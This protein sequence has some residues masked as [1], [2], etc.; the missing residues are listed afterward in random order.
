[1]PKKTRCIRKRKHFQ[2][3]KQRGGSTIHAAVYRN[4]IAEVRRL[5]ESGVDVNEQEKGTMYGL[6]PLMIAIVK[7]YPQIVNL[8]L[9]APG[10]NVNAKSNEGFTALHKAAEH[11]KINYV[12]QLLAIEGIHINAQNILHA[13]P[14]IIACE[15]NNADIVELLLSKEGID[16]NKKKRITN[17]TALTISCSY[18]FL[19]IARMLLA[20]DDIDVN[21]T[22]YD[23]S[24]ALMEGVKCS[25]EIT[26]LLLE[27]EGIDINAQND[28]GDTALM[29]A[30]SMDK[31]EIV[32]IL[33]ARDEIDV[34]ITN[35]DGDTAFDLAPTPEMRALFETRDPLPPIVRTPFNI[36]RGSENAI[37]YI[38]IEDGNEIV[39][40]HDEATHGRY[41]KQNTFNTFR[42]RLNPH[43]RQQIRSTNVRYHTARL[44]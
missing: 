37:A 1:M 30:V 32:Q 12:R 24:T 25:T 40:F 42:D 26:Q 33:L 15:K 13:T 10:F 39:D 20:R 29:L 14:L 16:V 44:V 3:R 8:I 23:G 17:E 38:P 2:T 36:P 21:A 5:I 27:K 41:Y 43:T 7:D 18:C 34:T 35:D 11:N 6:T 22:V 9:Q 4:N 19:N 28:Y 31:I